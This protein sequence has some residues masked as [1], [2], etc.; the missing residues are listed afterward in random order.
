MEAGTKKDEDG[1]DVFGTSMWMMGRLTKAVKEKEEQVQRISMSQ[2]QAQC[3][4]LGESVSTRDVS[5][6]HGIEPALM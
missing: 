6:E 3:K 5:L 2:T 1:Y 4:D